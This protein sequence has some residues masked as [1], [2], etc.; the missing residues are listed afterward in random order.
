MK[1][2]RYTNPQD[3]PGYL[4]WQVTTMWQK[5][6]R[7]VLEPLELTQPQFIL[8]HSCLWLNERDFE[9]KGVTQ[10]QIAQF[11]N[12]DVNVTSQVLRTLEKRGYIKRARHQTDTRA[13]IIT[14]TPEGTRLAIEGMNL[15]EESDK[16]FFE[17]L[18]ERKDGYMEI[19]QEFIRHKTDQ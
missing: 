7:R 13:N 11:A 14:T 4:L 1:S 2:S 6:V 19:M 18:A 8:L 12:V 16:N 17:L 3:S 15:V 5:E 10:V 9:G